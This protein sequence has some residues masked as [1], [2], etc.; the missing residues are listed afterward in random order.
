MMRAHSYR[1]K[2]QTAWRSAW[3]IWT[4]LAF[5]SLT[6]VRFLPAGYARAAMAGP[7]LLLVPGSL[8]LGALFGERRRLRGAAFVC[9]AILL[10]A[11]WTVFVSLVL[12]IFGVPIKAGSTYWILLV[13]SAA[14]AIAAEARLLLERPGSGRRVALK[15][16][17][18]DP[19]RSIAEADEAQT[20][21][22]TGGAGLYAVLAVVAGASL[23]A[24]GVY[25]YEH[26]PRPAPTG[27]TWM[28][29][30]KP[31]GKGA[32]AI[33]SG[34]AKLGFQI[35]HRESN[36]TAFRLS[37]AWA[38]TPPRPLA[39]SLT[40][41]IGPNK[42]FKGTLFVP[43]LPDGCSYRLVMVLTAAPHGH[44]SSMTNKVRTWSV[45]ADVHDP[46]KSSKK[47]QS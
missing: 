5:V 6:A 47:C 43:Q 35:V 40:L 29:W 21:G 44:I 24:G 25:A 16:D 9:Y 26:L 1:H 46:A 28:A 2:I 41:R 34:G 23:L 38:G 19:D 14:L 20:S 37:A 17:I 15:S 3:A 33:G 45:N 22:P 39:K 10:S 27:Y 36:T 32:I 31:Q 42:T 11:L 4:L 12:Y 13:V 30:T 8:T 7:I 18:P